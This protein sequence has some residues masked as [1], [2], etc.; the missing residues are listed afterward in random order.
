M[1]STE[2]LSYDSPYIRRTRRSAPQHRLFCLPH[3]GAGAGEYAAWA[4]LLPPEIEV[5]AIQLP[6]RE[7]RIREPAFTEAAELIPV[8]V[9]VLRPYL[10]LPFSFFGHSGSALFAF[11]LTRALH[12][13]GHHEPAHLF[14]S[15]QA[16]PHL[17]DQLPVLH[18]LTDAKFIEAVYGI[19]GMARAVI[20]NPE[21]K[22]LVL[23][24][25]RAD[26]TMWE[27]YRFRPG[28]PLTVPITA[29]GGDHDERA[30]AAAVEVWRHH[31]T[32]EFKILLLE[33]NHFFVR[34][35]QTEITHAVGAALR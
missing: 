33:G 14:V 15:G 9:Q 28:P 35:R 16:A 18:T 34:D 19:G 12:A 4:P 3:P 1:S 31:T 32:N 2:R 26:F 29:F 11:E 10:Q 21:L 27:R 6:G 22:D 7:D 8:V 17:T 20:D 13:H 23:P 24:A 30:P 25:L 5:V